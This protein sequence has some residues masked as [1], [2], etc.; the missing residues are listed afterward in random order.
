[1]KISCEVIQDLLPLYCDGVCSQDSR[2]TV[3]AHLEGCAKCRAELR[4]M[5]QDLET[6][7]FQTKD[8]KAAKAAAAAWKRGKNRAFVKGCL[9]ALL[10]FAVLVIGYLSIHWFSTADENDSDALARQAAAYLGYDELSIEKV[11]KRASYLAAL[12][13]DTDGNWCMCV[14]DRDRLF[15]NRWRA[16]GGKKGMGSGTISSWNYGSPQKEAVLIFCGGD[17]PEEVCW[18]QFQNS[19][20]TY[21]CPVER[22]LLLDI[23][24]IPD[25]SDINGH[26]ILLDRN[27]RELSYRLDSDALPQRA[28]AGAQRA[29]ALLR[30]LPLLCAP[31]APWFSSPGTFCGPAGS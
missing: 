15:E 31:R 13:R 29:P 8:E 9:I 17:I 22:D 7:L 20:I 16:N 5:E 30:I 25:S 24:I 3:E 14:F 23:F 4:L 26:P 27:Q 11:E 28:R 18:Y 2:Q 10:G 6:H 19:N 1:M 21:T 12:C